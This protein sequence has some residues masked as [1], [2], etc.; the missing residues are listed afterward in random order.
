MDIPPTDIAVS[1]RPTIHEATRVPGGVCRDAVLSEAEAVIRRRT[2]LDIVVCGDDTIQNR[3]LAEK[4]E[5]QV[6]GPYLHDNPHRRLV[7]PGALPHWQQRNVPP[8]A[9][10]GH[11]FYET[12]LTKAREA[13]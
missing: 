4:V 7:G 5:M 13:P 11:S 2:G 3:D 8:H 6:G 9:P 12:H 1:S 10:A